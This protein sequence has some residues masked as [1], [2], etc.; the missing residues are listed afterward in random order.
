M[1]WTEVVPAGKRFD[2]SDDTEVKME[3]VT[4]LLLSFNSYV[5]F[6]VGMLS[7]AHMTLGFLWLCRLSS[8]LG[9]EGLNPQALLLRWC[10]TPRT[11]VV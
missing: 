3:G 11:T 10:G 7:P 4:G 2:V 1:R 8:L 6:H 5:V 9:G